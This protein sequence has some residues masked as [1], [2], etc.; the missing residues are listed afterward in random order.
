MLKKVVIT[1]AIIS[2]CL[3][4][5]LLNVTTPATIGPFGILAVFIL[6]YVSLLGVVAYFFYGFNR[7]ISNL[8][9]A[10][11]VKKPLS[12]MTFKRAYYYSTVISA[13]PIMLIGLQS[14]GSVGVYEV[15]LVIIFGVIGCIY[16]SKRID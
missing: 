8:S 13:I 3:L 16:I 6:G 1:S 5:V 11:T 14:V 12:P 15:I 10:F 2:L 9:T 7:L 4:A